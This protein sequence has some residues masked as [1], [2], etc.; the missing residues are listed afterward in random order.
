MRQHN[1]FI[2]IWFQ[3]VREDTFWTNENNVHRD[4]FGSG[5]QRVLVASC[6]R[7]P[8]QRQ[9]PR[10]QSRHL[11]STCRLLCFKR[12]NPALRGQRAADIHSQDNKDDDNNNN[13]DKDEQKKF[14]LPLIED[15][16]C[17]YRRRKQPCLCRTEQQ[18]L[19]CQSPMVSARQGLILFQRSS[20]VPKYCVLSLEFSSWNCAQGLP[21]RG[22]QRRRPA[23]AVDWWSL[24]WLLQREIK[25]QQQQILLWVETLQFAF[26][27]QNNHKKPLK[28]HPT[29]W[30]N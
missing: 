23:V 25:A 3:D 10:Q 22:A 20:T 27:R 5:V 16:R 30:K 8:P 12:P 1:N 14:L 15:R 29:C 13:N 9:P 28:V 6:R 18:R 26:F 7:P 24:D 11:L 21:Q 17:R 19:R 4:H 2:L